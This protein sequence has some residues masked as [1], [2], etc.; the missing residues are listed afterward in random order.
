[1]STFLSAFLSTLVKEYFFEY[2]FEYSK[3]YSRV[4]SSFMELSYRIDHVTSFWGPS[5]NFF[6]LKIYAGDEIG[7]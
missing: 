3:K 6:A 7:F 2:F 1:M 4:S 5:E